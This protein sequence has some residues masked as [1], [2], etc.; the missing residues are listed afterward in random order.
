MRTLYKLLV[1][2]TIA[3]LA[4]MKASAN[5]VAG[6]QI[7]YKH[8]SSAGTSHTY[9]IEVVIFG[10]CSGLTY[11]SWANTNGAGLNIYNNGAQVQTHI[12]PMVI[13]ESNV[14]ISPVCP[15]AINQT[16]CSSGGTIVG[17][18]KYTFRMNVVLNG[19]SADWRFV[20]N[21]NLYN[22]G[23]LVSTAGRSDLAHLDNAINPQNTTFFI[24]ATLNNMN[25]QNNSPTFTSDPTPFFCVNIPSSFGLGAVE[26]DGDA[27]VYSLAEAEA[28]ALGTTFIT[29][30][31]PYTAA[32]PL[33]SVPGTF[34]FSTATGVTEFT[35]AQAPWEGIV[36]NR[37]TEMRNGVVVGT[38]AREMMFVMIN[39]CSNTSPSTPVAN[40][41]NGE[42][43]PGSTSNS[44][45]FK[46]CEA[47]Q[48]NFTFELAPVDPQGDNITITA[49][50]LPAGATLDITNNG[51]PNP[52]AIF[53]WDLSI[54]P[55]GTYQFF[56]TF[57]DDGCPL[58]SVKTVSYTVYV[59]PFNGNFTTTTQQP[60]RNMSNGSAWILP[61]PT[62]TALYRYTWMDP[63]FNVLQTTGSLQAYGD[64]LGDLT[65]GVYLV[66]A[67]NYRGCKRR[68]TILVDSPTY[69]AEFE[70]DSIVCVNTVVAFN[71]NF[72]NADFVAWDWDFG[73]GS[74]SN[75]QF[76]VLQYPVAGQYLIK[77]RATTDIGCVDSFEQIIT[78]DSVMRPEFDLARYD[79]C[80]GEKIG[81]TAHYGQNAKGVQWNFGDGGTLGTAPVGHL[82]YG[83]PNAGTYG[84]NM[85]VSY[86]SCPDVNFMRTVNVHEYPKVYLGYDTGL[87]YQGVAIELRNLHPEA[88][89]DRYSWNTGEVSAAIQAG[90]HGVFALTVTRNDCSATDSVTVNKDCYIDLPNAFIPG[91]GD[92]TGYFFP[93]GILAQ[94]VNTFDISIYN[95][96]GEQV[97]FSANPNGRGWD[98]SLNGQ[99]QPMGVYV[100]QINVTYKDGKTD[101]YQG[102][103]TLMR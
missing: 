38:S 33:T 5:H 77:L 79:I 102:N 10:D 85:N 58:S 3:F 70:V 54:V 65:P 83:Y 19:T 44:V 78:I 75:E 76:P 88:P 63:A 20:F 92:M 59:Q 64:T 94:G 30:N 74:S 47:Q 14:L 28:N 45:E 50:N 12:M 15:S 21:G 13:P 82:E 9:E 34:S 103:V 41:N 24:A 26:T 66:E 51:T 36:V 80:A 49:T 17:I 39:N 90:H 35:P 62:D 52:T 99:A 40:V 71:P 57:Q 101:K 84:I 86:R 48:V 29:Y 18:T 1:F 22:N 87:C 97:F 89:G 98:G 56:I 8:I 81:I 73:N 42:L 96:W 23:V 69:K 11:P 16:T 4:S 72:I 61:D 60:C 7:T 53:E 93:R 100:Y 2:V 27:M 37:V 55:A 67:E 91:S 25:G 43:E 32:A 31:P 68:F 46:V 6:G 95:R